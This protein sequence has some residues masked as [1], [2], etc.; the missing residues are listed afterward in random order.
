MNAINKCDQELRLHAAVHMIQGSRFR[1]APVGQSK[2]SL[3]HVGIRSDRGSGLRAPAPEFGRVCH[4]SDVN[5][6]RRALE[7]LQWLAKDPRWIR[8]PS[9][10]GW[11]E[12]GGKQNIKG[13]RSSIRRAMPRT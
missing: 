7:F 5:I 10:P 12:E 11:M 1:S 8:N 4:N 3:R 6:G 2:A 9:S 13:T